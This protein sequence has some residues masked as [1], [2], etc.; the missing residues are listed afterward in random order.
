MFLSGSDVDARGAFQRERR[1]VLEK[2]GHFPPRIKL[3]GT[4]H[5]RYI[6]SE[7]YAWETALAAG[8]SLDDLRAL[9]TRLVALRREAAAA[10]LQAAGSANLQ[11]S[12][13]A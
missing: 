3:A 11:I 8:A 2:E 6:L 5:S 12:G 1:R 9:V 7:I 4:G 10:A 13:G